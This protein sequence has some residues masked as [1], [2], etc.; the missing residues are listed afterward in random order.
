MTP[1]PPLRERPEDIPLLAKYPAGLAAAHRHGLIHRDIKP[2]NIWLEAPVGRV[3][4]LDFGMARSERDEVHITQSGTWMLSGS[5]A[6]L[7]KV[8]R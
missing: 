7:R 3:K 8:R 1:L 2:A 4:I 5:D 6:G